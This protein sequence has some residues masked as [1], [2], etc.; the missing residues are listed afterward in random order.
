MHN[1]N[2]IFTGSEDFINNFTWKWNTYLR[3]LELSVLTPSKI[4]ETLKNYLL[5]RSDERVAFLLMEIHEDA[6]QKI[7]RI[8]KVV[9][10]EEKDKRVLQEIV[11]TLPM[12]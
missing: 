10:N 4:I 3:T 9:N 12:K 8:Q 11:A 6:T 1:V 2:F 5:F 7:F